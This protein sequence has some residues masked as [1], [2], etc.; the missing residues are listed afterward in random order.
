MKRKAG[1]VWPMAWRAAPR[2]RWQIRHS[3][4]TLLAESA[5][6][7][8]TAWPADG[9]SGGEG[10]VNPNSLLLSREEEWRRWRTVR[11]TVQ[12]PLG[13]Q[14]RRTPRLRRGRFRLEL[15]GGRLAQPRSPAR[16]TWRA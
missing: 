13:R 3:L 12:Q 1:P 2:R 8:G 16:L 5:R 14:A 15:S 6:R 10:G 11:G 4:S 9:L 7:V